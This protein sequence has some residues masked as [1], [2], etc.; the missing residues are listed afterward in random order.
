M[1]VVNHPAALTA[2]NPITFRAWSLAAR[3]T[4]RQQVTVRCEEVVSH[5]VLCSATALLCQLRF[6]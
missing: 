6:Y 2:Q 1:R 5:Q 4:V 3:V